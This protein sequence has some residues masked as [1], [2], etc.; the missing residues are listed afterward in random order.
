M[1]Y[2]FDQIIDRKHAEGSYSSKWADNGVGAF[3]AFGDQ[4]YPEDRLP[5]FLADMDFKTAPPVIAAMQ[6]V[7]DHGLMG[8]SRAPKEY[9]PAVA[10]WFDRRFGWKVDPA[11]IRIHRGA[12]NAIKDILPHISAP[13]DGVIVLQPT[14]FFRSDVVACGRHYVGIPMN[15]DEGFYTINW[16]RL[17]EAMREPTNTFMIMEQPHNPTGR[18]WT[19]EEIQR[20]GELA[21]KYGITIISDEVH[22]DICRKGEKVEPLMKVL[23]P[24]KLVTIT[25]VNKTFNLAGLAMTNVVIEDEELKAKLGP[26]RNSASP[27]GIAAVIAAYTQCDDWVDALNEYLDKLI[28]HIIGRLH[29]ELPE[30]KVRKPDGT[31]VLWLDFSGFGLTDDQVNERLQLRAHLAMSD[32]RTM[33]TFPGEQYRRWCATCPISVA[34]EAIDRLVKAFKG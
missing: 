7:L 30:I 14:Y 2:D 17:E 23:G 28:D 16:E 24:E 6:K 29:A 12:H 5:L 10:G 32:G 13:G 18:I 22:M 33:D 3:N 26:S 11:N 19:V 9:G 25:G 21:K 34:D 4:P 8:Y 1:K 15:N 31:Y 27:F 20:I